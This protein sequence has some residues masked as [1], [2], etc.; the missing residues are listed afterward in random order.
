MPASSPQGRYERT[1][2]GPH[3]P[4]VAAEIVEGVPASGPVVVLRGNRV[5][6]CS[7]AAIGVRFV[8]ADGGFA[9]V[10]V[11][12]C[13]RILATTLEVVRIP[14]GQKGFVT[15]PLPLAGR[16]DLR[17]ADRTPPAGPRLRA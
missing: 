7:E 13:R 9:G 14:A 6:A 10:L 16:A 17:L 4:V 1:L 11:D 12:W 5:L 8:L 2:L 3:W 15:D